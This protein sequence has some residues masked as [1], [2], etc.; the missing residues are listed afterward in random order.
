[1]ANIL[2]FEYLME[3]E[4]M[5]K[6]SVNFDTGEIDVENYTDLLM[7]TVFGLREHT[8]DVLND[9]FEDRCFSRHR[10]DVNILLDL[11]GLKQYNPL[12]IVKVTH[13]R[14]TH[15]TLWIRFENEKGMSYADINELC[16]RQQEA[17][18]AELK[19]SGR[20]YQTY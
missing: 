15:D 11:I 2:N 6:V 8:V 17:R 9:F 4:V 16:R 18:V 13:G 19:A 10:P 14:T 5:S 20:Y 7:F 3:D 12:D 1:M